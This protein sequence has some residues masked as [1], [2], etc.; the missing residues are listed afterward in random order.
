MNTTI[1]QKLLWVVVAVVGVL[2][3]WVVLT[4]ST[5]SPLNT[6]NTATDQSSNAT[7]ESSMSEE[8]TTGASTTK[9]GSSQQ[10]ANDMKAMDSAAS[11]L[12]FDSDFEGF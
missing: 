7:T 11:S 8:S 5:H 1:S 3:G 2:L 10:F 12:N 4:N 9:K 6:S